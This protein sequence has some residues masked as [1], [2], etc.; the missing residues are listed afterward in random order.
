MEWIRRYV[1]QRS[2]AKREGLSNFE[3]V[4]MP[5]VRKLIE[6]NARDI[7]GLRVIPVDVFEFE[8]DDGEE[9]YVVNLTNKT[10]HCGSW[11]LIGIP[12]KHAMACIVLRKLDANEFVH[13]AYHIERYAKTYGPKFHGMPGHKM[14][15][16]TTFAKPLPPPFRKMPGRPDKR[17]RKKEAD[18]GKGG[19]KAATVVREYKPR[20]CSNC[21]DLGHYKKKCKNPPK[22]P[23]TKEKSKGGRPKKGSSSTQQLTTNDMPCTSSQPQTQSAS[24]VI[25]QISQIK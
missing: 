15:P 5:S 2:A 7:Y 4:L 24:C 23:T 19:N 22:P 10:C 20:K 18:E 9:S 1:T 25:D 14:W 11:T 17:K 12:C 16:T 3:G 13:E 21:G 6:K 8:V